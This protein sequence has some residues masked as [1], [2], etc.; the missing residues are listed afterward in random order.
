MWAIAAVERLDDLRGGVANK[1][2]PKQAR[3]S[4][5]G[6]PEVKPDSKPQAAPEVKPQAGSEVKPQAAPE[7]KP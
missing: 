4:M 7:V 1:E 2:P 3:P 5:P 6:I